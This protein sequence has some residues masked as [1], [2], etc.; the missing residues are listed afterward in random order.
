MRLFAGLAFAAAALAACTEPTSPT[1][2]PL[3]FFQTTWDLVSTIAFVSTRDDPAANP[4]L[5]AEIYLMAGDGENPRRITTNTDGDGFPALSPDGKKIVFDSNRLRA[6][7]EPLNT[8]DLFLM[9]SDGTEQVW[10]TRGSSASWSPDGKYVAFHRSASGTALPIR[11]DPGAATFDSD[12]FVLNVDDGLLHLA[13]PINLT[14]NPAAIDDDPDWSR[15][16]QRIVFT[17]HDV[18]DNHT[19]SVTAEIYVISAGGPGGG[20]VRLTHNA[21]EERAA[22]WSPDGTRIAFMCRRG[23][24]DFEICVMNA[25]G[26]GQVQLTDNTVF[27]GSPSWSPDGQQIAFSRVVAAGR[28]QLFRINLDSTGEVQLTNTPGTN[29]LARWGQLRVRADGQP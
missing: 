3:P 14:N 6:E 9:N 11:P 29:V 2:A 15:D 17:S 26:T 10:L 8:S 12:L 7:S 20:P 28:Q 13:A 4:L 16:G 22:T 19:N 18:D 5:A 25:N 1:D 21:E 24:T 23:G 27:D